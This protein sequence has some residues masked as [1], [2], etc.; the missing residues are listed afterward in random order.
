VPAEK[1]G[2]YTLLHRLAIGGM[3]EIWL[4]RQSGPAGFDRFIAIKRLLPNLAESQEFVQM[5]EDEARLAARLAHP[6][7]CQVYEFDRIG[8]SYYLAMEYLH[9]ETLASML[10]RS[11]REDKPLS[12][13]VVAYIAAQA[14][15]GLHF[16]HEAKD[17]DGHSLNLIHRDI[18]PSNIFITYDGQV[19]LLDF[20]IAKAA[21]RTTHTQAGS[22][23]GK[24]GYIAPEVY[25]GLPID[26]RAD[27]FSMGVVLWETLTRRRL[28]NRG[29]DYEILRAIVEEP[30]PDPR[31]VDTSIAASLAQTTLRALDKFPSDRFQSA[32]EMRRAVSVYLR[33]LRDEMDAQ[34][35]ATVMADLYGRIWID[36]RSSVLDSFKEGSDSVANADAL[37]PTLT[38][39]QIN[40]LTQLAI[41]SSPAIAVPA[42]Q[43]TRPQRNRGRSG[44]WL[45]SL[46]VLAVAGSVAA[47]AARQHRA[48]EQLPAENAGE[49][50]STVNTLNPPGNPPAGPAPTAAAAAP[51]PPSSPASLPSPASLATAPAPA[52]APSPARKHPARTSSRA[53][54]RANGNA[55]VINP[56]QPM[57]WPSQ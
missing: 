5:F 8:R 27:L 10:D 21:R 23:K 46:A 54:S 33:S 57:E 7:I 1:F 37:N 11:V 18:S 13:P 40:E 12:Q 55:K 51:L 16:A 35:V 24:F 36:L 3:G 26:R 9:G 47:L 28:Y 17:A 2:K 15:E 29:A 49:V 56:D 42:A 31:E 20:G 30:P 41:A 22:I 52:N 14:L 53:S 50:P 4:A 34:R 48:P 25:R 32:L 45:G 6:G 39:S 38:D 44:L 43:V 19:K